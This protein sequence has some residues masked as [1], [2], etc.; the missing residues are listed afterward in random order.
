V[1]AGHGYSLTSLEAD[2]VAALAANQTPTSTFREEERM[3][4]VF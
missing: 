4:H 2:R 1:L 3:M